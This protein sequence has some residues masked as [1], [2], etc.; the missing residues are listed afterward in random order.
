VPTAPGLTA[1]LRRRTA[2]LGGE[3]A[4]QACPLF[5]VGE[6]LA[7]HLDAGWEK[8]AEQLGCGHAPGLAG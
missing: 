3:L 4:G 1:A 7:G 2:A 6:K 8:L 5:Q